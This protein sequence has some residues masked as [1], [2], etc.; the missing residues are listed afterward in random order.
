VF[1]IDLVSSVVVYVNIY[2]RAISHTYIRCASVVRAK[3]TDLRLPW[4]LFSR[5]K[6]TPM[7]ER[8]YPNDRASVFLPQTRDA[9][10]GGTHVPLVKFVTSNEIHSLRAFV[11]ISL[12]TVLPLTASRKTLSTEKKPAQVPHSTL[13]RIF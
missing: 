12:F 5:C 6:R 7:R 13:N 10:A 9:T 2:S 8:G 4:P 3:I 1:A 11:R